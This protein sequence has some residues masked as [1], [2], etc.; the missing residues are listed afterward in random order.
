[1]K[2]ILIFILVVIILIFAYSEYKEY[3][4]FHPKNANIIASN[5]IDLDY[6]N[7]ETIFN[8]YR[9]LENANNYMQM[10]WSVNGIDVRSPEDDNE[11]TNLAVSKYGEKVAKL[12]YFKNILERSKKLKSEGYSN[13]D[14]KSFETQGLTTKAYTLKINKEKYKQM[15]LEM[16][17]EKALFSGERNQFVYEIQKLLVKKGYDIPIDG[18]YKNVTSDALMLFEEKNNLFTDGKIDLISLN[19]LLK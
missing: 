14:I 10:Q 5:T 7:K 19:L 12:N 8:Y 16:M 2:K 4:R 1:M 17:P 6:H 9:A 3:Q 11:E 15:I 13:K 18:V